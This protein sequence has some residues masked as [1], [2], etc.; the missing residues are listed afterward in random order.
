VNAE[1]TTLLRDRS[2]FVRR[3]RFVSQAQPGEHVLREFSRPRPVFAV[4]DTPSSK[5]AAT[6]P[7][8]NND[9][10]LL[11]A[12]FPT[13]PDTLADRRREAHVWLAGPHNG[14]GSPLEVAARDDCVLWK[15]GR[16]AFLGP[17]ERADE[18]LAPLL[19]FAFVEGQICRLEADVCSA[20]E[21]AG[22]DIPLTNQ[23]APKDVVHWPHVNEMTR[24]VTLG[25][26]RYCDLSCRLQGPPAEL[27]ATARQVL[28]D[29]SGRA[30]L[31]DRLAAL[32]GRIEAMMNLY[33]AANDRL[34]AYSY[35]RREW[36]LEIW[37]ILVIVAEMAAIFV[38]LLS[39]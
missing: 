14:N 13:D 2:T 30:R 38:Q 26:M 27:S 9:E 10:E 39:A 35:F 33:S 7:R 25:R 31:S 19:E 16:A 32:N 15:H 23:I 36:W 18:M 24:Q 37:I 28:A 12:V 5:P 11:F 6:P 3:M 20:W 29:L 1:L 34:S 17:P 4:C 21:T 22:R 8:S